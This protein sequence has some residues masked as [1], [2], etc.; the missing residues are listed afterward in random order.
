VSQPPPAVLVL[1]GNDPTA[2]A[3]LGADIETLSALGCK[4]LPVVTSIT[5]QDTTNVYQIEPVT[6]QLLQNQAQALIKDIRIAAIKIG[7]MG[8]EQNLQVIKM[9][10]QQLPGIPVVLDPILRAGGGHPLATHNLI[11]AIQQLYPYTTLI[12]PNSEEARQLGGD[13]S[14]SSCAHTLLERG[15]SAVMITG[16]HEETHEV[17][18]CLY[19]SG[20]TECLQWPRLKNSYHGSGCTFASAATAAL[21]H[22]HTINEAAKRAQQFTWDS[23]NQ[24]YRL[25]KGQHHPQ[26]IHNDHFE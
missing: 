14:L 7:L 4:P 5:V 11:E 17:S 21:A 16:A 1:A 23:L 20:K 18:N 25:G 6:P 15:C 24:G 10:L 26:R 19:S 8:S 13:N 2:G 22:G 12:T 9:L 3:G